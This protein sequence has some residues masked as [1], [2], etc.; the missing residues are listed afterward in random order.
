MA[1]KT[2]FAHPS[3]L[4]LIQRPFING[5]EDLTRRIYQVLK[6]THELQITPE[7]RRL[8]CFRK[9]GSKSLETNTGEMGEDE[10]SK[11][12]YQKSMEHISLPGRYRE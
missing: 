11:T 7:R 9:R 1:R 10:A 3:I 5:R 12:I 8:L 2:L 6:S 4:V